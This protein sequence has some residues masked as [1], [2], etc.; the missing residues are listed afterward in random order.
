MFCADVALN[1][2]TEGNGRQRCRKS[3]HNASSTKLSGALYRE[4]INQKMHNAN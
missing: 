2:K 4:V 1:E 3:E